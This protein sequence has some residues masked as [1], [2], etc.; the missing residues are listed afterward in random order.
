M[1][2]SLNII[3]IPLDRLK[4]SGNFKRLECWHKL[5]REPN[6]NRN[7]N[8]HKSIVNMATKMNLYYSFSK[9]LNLHRR[10]S[11]FKISETI[12]NIPLLN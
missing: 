10:K 5:K 9:I 8:P 6:K 12:F 11:I 3:K 2:F 7:S 4:N 1:K